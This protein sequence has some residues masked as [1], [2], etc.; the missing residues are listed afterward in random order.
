[1]ARF[2][3]RLPDIG[4]GIAEGE[5]VAWH[6]TPGEQVV[7][8]QEMVEVMTDKATVTIGVPRKG[9]IAQLNA[10]IGERVKVGSVLVVID[11]SASEAEPDKPERSGAPLASVGV[12]AARAAREPNLDARGAAREPGREQRPSRVPPAPDA[13]GARP[14][15]PASAGRAPLSPSQARGRERAL[16]PVRSAEE[17]LRTAEEPPRSIPAAQN[18]SVVASAVGDIREDLPGASFFARGARPP[19]AAP[20]EPSAGEFF[21]P[22]PLATPATRKLARD[23][24]IDLRR[25]SPSGPRGRVTKDDVRG[26]SPDASARKA[27]GSTAGAAEP[28]EERKPFVGLR[29][30]IAERMQLARHKAAH[31]TFVE[32]VEVDRLM[33]VIERLRPA[34]ARAQTKL[35][36]LPFIIKA[37]TLA[38]QKH[39]ILNSMLDEASSEL[40]YRRYYHIGVATATQQG[41]VV[42][43]VRDADQKSVLAIAKDI[44][45]LAEGARQG[46]LS[47]GELSGSTFTVT[48]LGKQGGLLATPVL[49]YPEVGILGVHRVKQRPVVRDGQ[50]VVGHVMHLSLSL[51]HR[52]VDGHVGAAFAYELIAYLEEPELLL[53]ELS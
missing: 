40:V 27:G 25:V 37:A 48:S 34:A 46:R 10:A 52:V 29:R 7:E 28:R 8:D 5:V 15:F 4:E 45:R 47:A 3:F 38:L 42:P 12:V 31:F 21:A 20:G 9:R 36:Y 24:G 18:A 35:S 44:E 11:E 43:V 26:C 33:A 14:R 16:R 13:D 32:E 39:P 41:L 22:K 53:L 49:N 1:V 50:I 2:E 19:A 6:V 17:P 23:L 30:R 51:D